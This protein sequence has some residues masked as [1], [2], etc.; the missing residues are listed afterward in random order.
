MKSS[1][2]GTMYCQCRAL[3]LLSSVSRAIEILWSF[4]DPL[5]AKVDVARLCLHSQN[6]IKVQV[7]AKE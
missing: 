1:V 5:L 4:F 7:I 2:V 6:R 3:N